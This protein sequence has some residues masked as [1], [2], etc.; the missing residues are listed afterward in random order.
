M[1]RG[2][3]IHL[4]KSGSKK[5]RTRQEVEEVKDLEAQLKQDRQ[6]F[7]KE[8]KSL[9]ESQSCKFRKWEV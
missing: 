2:K 8:V 7:L 1:E 9:R 3:A 6:G 4:L 5:K